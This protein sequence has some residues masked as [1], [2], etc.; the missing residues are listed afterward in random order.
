[1]SRWLKHQLGIAPK[2]NVTN[3]GASAI[4]TLNEQVE[5]SQMRSGHRRRAGGARRT[6]HEPRQSCGG[7]SERQEGRLA[8]GQAEEETRITGPANRAGRPSVVSAKLIGR[9][10]F[11]RGT[12]HP[13]DGP[14]PPPFVSIVLWTNPVAGRGQS[15][16]VTVLLRQFLF[17]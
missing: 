14:A 5:M 6:G 4:M 9:V 15:L 2:V 7:A 3:A 16:R 1:M 11:E 10:A 13:K 12:A 8:E 17:Q